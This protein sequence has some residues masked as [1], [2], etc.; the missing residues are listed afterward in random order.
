MCYFL[1]GMLLIRLFYLL[2]LFFIYLQVQLQNHMELN[3]SNHPVIL[4]QMGKVG[5]STLEYSINSIFS[6]TLHIHRYFFDSHET[7]GSF[8]QYYLK[9]IKHRILFNYYLK[10]PNVRIITLYRDPLSRNISS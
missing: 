9:R 3:N 5:S 1:V 4:Y 6:P 7:R 10:N 2:Y 8:F